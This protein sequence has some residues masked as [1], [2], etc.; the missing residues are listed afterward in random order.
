M[1][2]ALRLVALSA[3]ASVAL[4][5][6]DINYPLGTWTHTEEQQEEGGVCG[7]GSRV[8]GVAWGAQSAFV[9]LSGDEG[10]SVRVLLASTNSTTA[11]TEVA[12]ASSFPIVLAENATFSSSGNL[13]LPISLPAGYVSGS[14]ATLY[15]EA[16][17]DD[18]TISSCAEVV[19]IPDLNNGNTTVMEHGQAVV[20]EATGGNMTYFDYYCSN[21]TIPALDTCSCH[22]HGTSPHCDDT[23][24]AERLETATAECSGDS[25]GAPSSSSAPSPTPSSATGTVGEAAAQTSAPASGASKVVV[26]FGSLALGAAALLLLQ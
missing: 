20:N 26:G 2:A 13:C 17:G 4:A 5:H 10:N 12:D 3:L 24:S 22:C 14:R 9:S 18:E 23:C 21:S 15:V 8:A 6:V 11:D 1:S 16:S 7:G 19:L 25:A